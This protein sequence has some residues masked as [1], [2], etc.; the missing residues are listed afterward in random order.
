MNRMPSA[1]IYALLLIYIVPTTIS[2]TYFNYEYAQDHEFLEWVMFGT[3]L[4][5]WKGIAWPYFL[6]ERLNTSSSDDAA[7][8]LAKQGDAKA[9][10]KLGLAVHDDAE[11]VR[12]FRKAAD[13]GLALAQD[14]L[15]GMYASGRGVPQSDA[16]AVKW[17]RKAAN[18]GLALAQNNLGFM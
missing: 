14:N 18:Q 3:R 16:E 7:F 6:W 5:T 1:L 4:A 13:Q 10:Y 8:P 9:Q 11:A 2:A 12:W 15:G 17:F